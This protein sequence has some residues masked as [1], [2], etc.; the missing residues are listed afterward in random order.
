MD[1]DRLFRFLIIDKEVGKET[2][3]GGLLDNWCGD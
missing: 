3:T 2:V 1:Y